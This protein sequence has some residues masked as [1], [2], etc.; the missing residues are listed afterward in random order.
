MPS[1]K[2]LLRQVMPVRPTNKSLRSREHLTPA[3]VDKL[4]DAAKKHSGKSRKQT[5]RNATLIL[6]AYKHGLRAKE[7]AELRWDQIEL[8]KNAVFHVW[9]AKDG[10][11]GDHPLDG[12]E[13]RALRELRRNW[14][15]SQFVFATERQG[16]F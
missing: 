15:D 5:A 6:F 9:R 3:E 13:Q 7:I 16:P 11:P 14:T 8:G 2:K 1:R 10:K 12:D 4:I